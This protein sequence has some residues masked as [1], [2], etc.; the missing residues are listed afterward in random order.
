MRTDREYLDQVE[1]IVR[2]YYEGDLPGVK[3]LDQLVE[4]F[5]PLWD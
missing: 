2:K 3:A 5:K 4:I 1:E